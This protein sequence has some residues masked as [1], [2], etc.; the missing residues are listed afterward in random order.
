MALGDKL[1]PEQTGPGFM[2]LRPTQKPQT[3]QHSPTLPSIGRET[4]YALQNR[5]PGSIPGVASSLHCRAVSAW[6]NFAS[7]Q[8]RRPAGRR[9]NEGGRNGVLSRVIGMHPGPFLLFQR[10]RG[11]VIGNAL[12]AIVGAQGFWLNRDCAMGG[13]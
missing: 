12:Y 9:G 7:P 2:R 3:N 11:F 8:D 4:C 1:N 13:A 6:R 10:L 5:L